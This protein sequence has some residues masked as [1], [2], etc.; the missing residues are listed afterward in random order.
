M[1]AAGNLSRRIIAL[2]LFFPI[3]VKAHPLSPL[4]VNPQNHHSYLLL[5]AATWKDSEA[6]AVAFGGHLATVRNRAEEDW[7][8]KTF[9]SYGGQQRLLWIG[10]SDIAKNFIIAGAAVN[11]PRTPTGRLVSQTMPGHTAKITS[12]F[13]IQITVRQ[14]NGMIGL[15]EGETPS[16]SR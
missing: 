3:M 6:E 13:I 1:T 14:I 11:P 12:L 7:I 5:S 10:L 15:T 8:F 16:D 4:I 2:L 9:G